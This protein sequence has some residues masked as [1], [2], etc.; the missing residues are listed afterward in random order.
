M[1]QVRGIFGFTP[2]DNIGKI[3]FPAVQ[4]GGQTVGAWV[5]LRSL[6][7]G[8]SIA[9][10]LTGQAAWLPHPP[11]PSPHQPLQAAPAFPDSFPQMF[12]TRKDVRCVLYGGT[13]RLIGCKFVLPP[14]CGNLP[15]ALPA[16]LIVPAPV[17]YLHRMRCLDPQVSHSFFDL[18]FIFALV[19][20][21]DACLTPSTPHP[22]RPPH[23]CPPQVPH[24]LRYRPGPL[25]PHDAGR[26]AAPGSHQD[27][28][29]RIALLP[30]A[31]GGREYLFLALFVI[32]GH[33][34]LLAAAGP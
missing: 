10:R 19:L 16:C 13:V 11:T 27:R 9:L 24:P 25:L 12:G 28:P 1:N 3:A 29:H 4:V 8:V 6:G 18:F 2:E 20:P 34:D 15:F 23:I 5:R 26:S 22:P 31:A 30:S 33:I 32:P 7:F 14:A 21:H 17:P